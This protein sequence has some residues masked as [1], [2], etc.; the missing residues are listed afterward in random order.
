MFLERTQQ[1]LEYVKERLKLINSIIDEILPAE[2][3]TEYKPKVKSWVYKMASLDWNINGYFGPETFIAP[4][5]KNE[6]YLYED[7]NNTLQDIITVLRNKVFNYYYKC[8]K[9]ISF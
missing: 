8:K 9:G 1:M 3:A 5:V 4:Q 2:A 7:E 6:S